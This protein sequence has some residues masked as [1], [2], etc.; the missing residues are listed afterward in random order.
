MP[1]TLYTWNAL[2]FSFK[3]RDKAELNDKA[4]Y[5]TIHQGFKFEWLLGLI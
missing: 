3:I 4:A 2:G 5:K 1:N